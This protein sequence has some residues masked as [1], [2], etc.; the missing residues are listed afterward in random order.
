MASIE[1]EDANRCSEESSD[2]STGD[3]ESLENPAL[4]GDNDVTAVSAAVATGDLRDDSWNQPSVGSGGVRQS[5]DAS[6][7]VGSGGVRQSVDASWSEGT[8]LPVSS[9]GAKALRSRRRW[10]RMACLM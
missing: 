7:S 2:G 6:P 5:V 4:A 8:M 9:R 10:R 1:R 3:I